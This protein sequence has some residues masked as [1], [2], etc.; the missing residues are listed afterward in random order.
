MHKKIYSNRIIWVDVDEVLVKFRPMFN[1]FLRE[2]YKIQLPDNFIAKNWTYD[3]VLPKHFDFMDCFNSLPSDWPEHLPAYDGARDFLQE[4][5]KMGNYIILITQVPEACVDARLRNLLAHNFYY[6]EIYFTSKAK[7][8]YALSTLKR[9]ENHQQIQN[10]LIDDR[11][12]N[13][14]DFLNNMPNME[15]VFSLDI[16][17]NHPE[18]LLLQN[19]PKIGFYKDTPTMCEELLKYLRG[20]QPKDPE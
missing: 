7:S 8:G 10:I 2:T 6:D 12:K 16:E 13:C 4:L 3:E 5:K 19:E 18:M 14:V 15:K 17:I 9:I 20:L 11:A 1:K